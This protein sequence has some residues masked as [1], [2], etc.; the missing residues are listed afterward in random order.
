[1]SR[2]RAHIRNK[3]DAELEEVRFGRADDVLRR[4]HPRTWRDRLRAFW[5]KEIEVP[6]LPLGLS[7]AVILA[8]TAA[9]QLRERAGDGDAAL[10]GGREL[11]EA[12]GNTYWKDDYERAVAFVESDRQS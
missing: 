3:L 6:V 2:E 11:I 5:N 7:F 1:M 9:S 10:P 4:T 8:V 12:G